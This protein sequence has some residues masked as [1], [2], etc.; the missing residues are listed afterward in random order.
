MKEFKDTKKLVQDLVKGLRPLRTP[1]YDNRPN[2]QL[3]NKTIVDM[4]VKDENFKTNDR[5][6]NTLIQQEENADERTNYNYLVHPKQNVRNN[7]NSYKLGTAS[8]EDITSYG[9]GTE[10]VKKCIDPDAMEKQI[11]ETFDKTFSKS[12]N[13]YFTGSSLKIIDSILVQESLDSMDLEQEGLDL[14]TTDDVY[15]DAFFNLG[16]KFNKF[17]RKETFPN[18]MQISNF[19]SMRRRSAP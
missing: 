11:V 9:N 10:L 1:S 5:L 8:C 7:E 4:A 12:K 3:M 2:V 16:N 14:K 13:E 19:S 17:Q 6:Y 18:L 15:E